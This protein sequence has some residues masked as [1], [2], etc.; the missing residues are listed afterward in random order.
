MVLKFYKCDIC[1]NVAIKAFDQGPSLFC[2]GQEMRE[3]VADTTDAALEKHVPAV[4]VNGNQV[5]VQIGSVEHP[6]IP[7]HYITLIALETEKG[8][9]IAPLEPGMKPRAEFVITE[10][11]KPLRVYEYC[12]IHSL[13]KTEAADFTVE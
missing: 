5:K 8:Y 11:D 7:E 13:W 3:L 9:Q 6:M 4:T 12:N 1:G 2:C 10:G